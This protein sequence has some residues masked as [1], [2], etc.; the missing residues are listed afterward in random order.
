MN[1]RRDEQKIL[2]GTHELFQSHELYVVGGYVRDMV[3]GR[4]ASDLDFATSAT[5]DQIEGVLCQK[6]TLRNLITMGKRFGT[7]GCIA[8]VVISEVD[9]DDILEFTTYR[10]DTYDGDSRKPEIT[11]VKT[12]KE[13]LKRRDFTIN[14]LAMHPNTLEVVDYFNGKNDIVNKIIRT[15]SDPHKT[16]DDDPLRMMRAIRFVSQLGFDVDALTMEAIVKLAKGIK[17]VSIERVMVELNKTLQGEHVSKALRLFVKCGLAQHIIPEMVATYD[18]AQPKEYHVKDVFEHTLSVI[19]NV[20][21][22]RLDMR[23]AALFHDIG[24]PQT[25][26]VDR[27]IIHFLKHELVGAVMAEKIM[28]RLKYS[29]DLTM[30]VKDMVRYHMRSLSA[31]SLKAVRKL[32]HGLEVDSVIT[33]DDLLILSAAD[34]TSSKPERVKEGLALVEHI[35]VLHQELIDIDEDIV[36]SPLNG[37]E[38]MDLLCIGPG[39]MIGHIKDKIIEAILEEDMKPNDKEEATQVAIKWYNNY[40]IDEFNDRV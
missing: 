1:I 34:I 23:L 22:D 30:F 20:P 29:I 17:R 11:F 28:K 40:S 6:C 10:S 21:A 27:G 7:L 3:M 12:L 35:K 26:S 8:H 38:I 14:A 16:F 33:L 18:I 19:E 31:Q 37:D 36:V 39:K 5:P 15:P 2:K 24:K 32:V 13:D 9:S 25:M 4:E